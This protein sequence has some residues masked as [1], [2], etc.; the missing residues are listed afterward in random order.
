MLLLL[1]VDLSK[2]ISNHPEALFDNEGNVKSPLKKEI[3]GKFNKI[4]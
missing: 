3:Q 2:N 4:C 1:S